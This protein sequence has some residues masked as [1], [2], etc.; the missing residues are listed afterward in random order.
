MN[1]IKWLEE[2]FGSLCD[3]DWEHFY[4]IKINTLDNPGWSVKIDIAET[5]YQDK[6][7]VSVDID[8]GDDDWIKCYFKDNQFIG[9]GD[10]SK[11]E[12]IISVFRKWIE[13]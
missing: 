10:A 4:G 8:N 6:V 13:T 3:G 2:W 9:V 7:P 5:C 11:L 1:T 12:M